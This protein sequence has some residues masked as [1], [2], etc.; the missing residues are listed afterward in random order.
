MKWREQPNQEWSP[1]RLEALCRQIHGPHQEA[2]KSN[3]NG[4]VYQMVF[5]FK[6]KT[7]RYDLYII[8][9]RFRPWIPGLIRA[10]FLHFSTV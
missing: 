7:I 8:P 4:A 5:D 3:N 1:A 10:A 6:L 2:P 9:V